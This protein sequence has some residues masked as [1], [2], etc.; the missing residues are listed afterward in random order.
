MIIKN[1]LIMDP[2]SGFCGI[3]DL[4]IQNGLITETGENLPET[5]GEQT[6]DVSGLTVAPGLV[7]T[8]V[9]FRDPGFTYKETI[10]TGALAAAKG[11]VY[12]CHMYG[13]YLSGDRLAPGAY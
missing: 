5:Q 2:D 8:H 11:G 12:F 13:K 3:S 1:G 4:R 9:D 10:H 7:D 6:I